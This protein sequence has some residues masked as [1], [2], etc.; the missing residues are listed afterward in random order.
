MHA[1]ELTGIEKGRVT[2]NLY[3]LDYQ[4]HYKHVKDASVTP[5]DTKLIYEKGERTQEAG[6]RITGDADPNLGK[7]LNFE[8]QPK[9]PAALHGVLLEEKHNQHRL[10]CGNIKEHI[11]TL[12]G[13][14]KGKKPSLRAQLAQ[15]KKT[16]NAAPKKQAAKSKNKGLEV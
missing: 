10:N 6:K 5:G 7:F 16:V 12:S 2:G 9:D 13:K 15:D 1:V 11:E 8:E 3:E 14:G 4:K